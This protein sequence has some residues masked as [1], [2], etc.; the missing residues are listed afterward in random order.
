MEGLICM[1]F[2]FL[3]QC[4]SGAPASPAAHSAEPPVATA[5]LSPAPTPTI[6]PTLVPPTT[7]PTPEAARLRLPPPEG[8]PEIVRG[9]IA[10][11]KVALT[12]DAGAGARH[13]P[14]ILDALKA[15]NLKVTMFLTGQ[16]AERYPELT[17]RIGADGH[18][19][20]NH[21]YSHPEFTKLSSPAMIAEIQRTEELVVGL[22]GKS[23]KPWFR[24]P[25]GN[26]DA[27][28]LAV[29]GSQGYY[30]VYWTLDSGDWRTDYSNAD[31]L[32]IVSN[33]A[34]GGSIVVQHLDSPQTAA[35]LPQI[36]QR[37]QARGLSIV[38][39][40]HLFAD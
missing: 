31:V 33:R 22:T 36:I 10:S 13:T 17:K 8:A 16:W 27:R 20:A 7:T 18:E 30:S 26:R 19:L 11:S 40:S 1:L 29:I 32:N 14:A 15:A 6:A 28:V 35:V 5:T 4:G 2:G 38:T 37:L 3:I 21:S 24:P 23:T 12:F 39:L 25:F 34:A 9:D